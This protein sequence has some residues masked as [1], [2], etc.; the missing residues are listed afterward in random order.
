[1]IYY[2]DSL[3]LQFL[4][5]DCI[6]IMNQILPTETLSDSDAELEAVIERVTSGSPSLI[7]F[8]VH[9]TPMGKMNAI[10]IVLTSF[11]GGKKN[12]RTRDCIFPFPPFATPIR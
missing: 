7:H 11:R 12:Q 10:N 5:H 3:D 8:L 2:E 9:G 4:L 1:M 6:K